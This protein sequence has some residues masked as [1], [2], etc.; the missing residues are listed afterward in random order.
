MLT[1]TPEQM[2]LTETSRLCQQIIDLCRDAGDNATDANVSGLM[3][4]LAEQHRRVRRSVDERLSVL[5][6]LPLSP[7]PDLE[8]LKKLAVRAKQLFVSDPGTVLLDERI[9]DEQKLLEH[10]AE[11]LKED[12]PAATRDCLED[13]RVTATDALSALTAERGRHNE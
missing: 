8:S 7:D 1:R 4:R 12:L 10:V 5:D 11:A 9:E 13:V 2:A 6:D 3:S